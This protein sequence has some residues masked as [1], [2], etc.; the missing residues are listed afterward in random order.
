MTVPRLCMFEVGDIVVPAI[1][2]EYDYLGSETLMGGSIEET[3]QS[4]RKYKI[5]EVRGKVVS[6]SF[7]EGP[8]PHLI[9]EASYMD[10]CFEKEEDC[11][12][13]Q[14]AVIEVMY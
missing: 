5:T 10:Y 8:T 9:G 3:L 7:V 2:P 12:S 1:L 14:K 11:P 13:M 4:G 6:V